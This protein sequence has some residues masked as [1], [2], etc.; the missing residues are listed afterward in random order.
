MVRSLQQGRTSRRSGCTRPTRRRS[1]TS[2]P[3]AS[4]SENTEG[5]FYAVSHTP[6][7]ETPGNEEF[8]AKY[9]EMFGGEPCP[10][11][12]PTRSPPAQVL[13]AA[14]EAVG[15]SSGQTSSSWPTGCARTRSRRSSA[16]SSWDETGARQGEFLIG[17]WQD[18]KPEIVLPEDAATTD[19]IVEGTSPDGATR[20]NCGGAPRARRRWHVMTQFVQTSS[21]GLLIGG[22]YALVASG[23]T[24]IFGVMRVIN[25]AHG[26]FLILAAFLTCSLWNAIGIDPL[27][28]ILITTPVMFAFGLGPLPGARSAG[29]AARRCPR[30]CC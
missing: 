21:S 12:R 24:L 11:T 25:I 18:G 30:R 5:V 16:R 17:Q 15:T 27:L 28:A 9:E 8:V 20:R 3:R 23:L 13:Q 26:A 22:V 6:E 7:A 4:A 1:A 2:T 14:V 10:R 29:S 19:T